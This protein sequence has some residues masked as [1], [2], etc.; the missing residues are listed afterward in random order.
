MLPF[1]R[2]KERTAVP[3][4]SP[5]RS[6]GEGSGVGG[7]CDHASEAREC[8]SARPTRSQTTSRYDRCRTKT[9]VVS[10][11]FTN[12]VLTL[13]AASHHRSVLR[14][15]RLPRTP[16]HHRGRRIATQ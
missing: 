12:R 16:P 10:A 7:E 11:T 1:A 9:L 3:L 15:L 4:P 14:R 13:P 5:P 8:R 2:C 6:G